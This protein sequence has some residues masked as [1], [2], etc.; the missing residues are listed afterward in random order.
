MT[1]PGT[2]VIISS[3]SGGGKTS[4]CRR[5]LTPERES[6]GWRFSISYTTRDK[7]K[8]E[9]NG[10]EYFFVSDEEFARLADTD[11]F[12][13]HFRVHLYRYGTPREQLNSVIAGGGV[14]LLD[15][16]VQGAARLRQEYPQAVSIFVQP[17]SIEAL[18]QRLQKRGTETE[19]QLEV[20]LNN[21]IEEMKANKDFDHTVINEDLDTAVDQVLKII[22]R[23]ERAENSK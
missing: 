17:P 23:N 1:R 11:F 8:G 22:S 5:L 19:D 10:R 4:I 3:P 18:R 7:R 20:R 12:A 21:S 2:I 16:D 6:A 13:E 15:V 9:E 14:I